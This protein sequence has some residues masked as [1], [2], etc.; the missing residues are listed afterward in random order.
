MVDYDGIFTEHKNNVLVGIGFFFSS[1]ERG[2]LSD[3]H[4]TSWANSVYC[5]EI[6]VKNGICQRDIFFGQISPKIPE[7]MNIG[8]F[9]RGEY[10]LFEN[11]VVDESVEEDDFLKTVT[12]HQPYCKEAIDQEINEGRPL[13]LSSIIVNVPRNYIIPIPFL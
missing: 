11:D 8:P 9:K 6:M 3:K 2:K 13:F 5:L 4:D 1:Q 12:V 7:F 10:I